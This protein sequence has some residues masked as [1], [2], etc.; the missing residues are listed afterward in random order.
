LLIHRLSAAGAV[1][2]VILALFIGVYW[3]LRIAVDFLYYEHNDW[4]SGRGFVL[5]HVLLTS[6]FTFLAI[7]NLVLVIWKI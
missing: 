4:P 3:A 1:Q 2:L 6:L 5:G 7:T